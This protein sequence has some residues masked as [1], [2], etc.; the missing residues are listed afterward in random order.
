[1]YGREPAGKKNSARH[2]NRKPDAL[3]TLTDNSGDDYW[4]DKRF[5]N[6]INP[7]CSEEEEKAPLVDRRRAVL[8]LATS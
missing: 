6:G 5:D 2:D 4:H 1:M 7:I 3:R 8:D